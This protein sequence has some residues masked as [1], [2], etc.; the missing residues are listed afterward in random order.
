MKVTFGLCIKNSEKTIG[1]NI[2]SIANQ[3]YP[4]EQIEIIV[5]DGNSTDSTVRVAKDVLSKTEIT[6]FVISDHGAGLGI[7]RQIVVDKASGECIIYLGDDI[8]LP[9]DFLEKQVKF[10][11]ENPHV[12]AAVPESR[13]I[14]SGNIVTDVQNLLFSVVRNLS[15]GTAYRTTAMRQVG[16]FDKKIKGASEDREVMFRITSIGWKILVN[17][18]AKFFHG[19]KETMQSVRKR[20]FWYGYGDHFTNHKHKNLYKVVYY[21]PP[22]HSL[23]GIKRSFKAYHKYHDKKAFLIPFLC[24]FTSI[25]WCLGLIISHFDGYGH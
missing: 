12:G 24:F 15:N 19:R 18:E 14:P 3:H 8:T 23:W 22:T 11:H 2:R 21:L 4:H 17:S 25:N 16:G 13:Y 9:P 7:A 6:G 20:Y 10:M 5:V 1:D